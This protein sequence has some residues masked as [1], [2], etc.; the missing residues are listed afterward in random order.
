VLG[1]TFRWLQSRVQMDWLMRSARYIL[2]QARGQAPELETRIDQHA[3]TLAALA[4]RK[5]RG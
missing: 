5:S 4:V 2:R 1:R 3:A